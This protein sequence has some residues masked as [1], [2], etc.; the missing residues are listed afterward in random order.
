MKTVKSI[1]S[2]L[3]L[4]GLLV[5]IPCG[6]GIAADSAQN[7]VDYNSA[8]TRITTTVPAQKNILR[9]R[10]PFNPDLFDSKKVAR[11]TRG[12]FSTPSLQGPNNIQFQ[13]QFR[14]P[15]NDGQNRVLTKQTGE[16]VS[17]QPGKGTIIEDNDYNYLGN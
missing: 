3:V 14:P 15:S 2:G 10:F 16:G 8:I 17:T 11:I 5:T 9:N 6:L 1:S 12:D 13:G 7:Y 4:S